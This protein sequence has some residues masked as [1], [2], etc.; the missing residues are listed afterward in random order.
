[1]PNVTTGN[2]T[3]IAFA[4]SGFTPSVVSFDGLEETLEGLIDSDLSTTNYETMVPA[5]LIAV[6]PM[7]ATIRWDNGDVPPLGTVELITITFPLESGES[8][9][10]T[11]AGTGF[12]SG[13]TGPN[14]VNN[15]IAEASISIQF[16]GK[17]TEPTYTVGS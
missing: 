12:I 14:L 16:D 7:T 3:T 15:T 8:T 1:M 2:S 6:S 17:S 5:D 13:R 10:A 4:T 9:G 11:L